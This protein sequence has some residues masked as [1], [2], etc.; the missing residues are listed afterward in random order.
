[1]SISSGIGDDVGRS[2]IPSV[3]EI[4]TRG[5]VNVNRE[6]LGILADTLQVSFTELG[7]QVWKYKG[8][9]N[10]P[11]L[12]SLISTRMQAPDF[13]VD[14]QMWKQYYEDLLKNLPPSIREKLEYDLKSP[15]KDRDN[16]YLALED[17]LTATARTLASIDASKNPLEPGSIAQRYADL[18]ALLPLFTAT[19]TVQLGTEFFEKAREVL[20]EMGANYVYRDKISDTINQAQYSLDN[21]QQELDAH[22]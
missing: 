16:A 14:N 17:L 12:P 5:I 15:L 8:S 22:D 3:F 4:E 6:R 18:N 13:S 1:M 7:G 21:M 9:A 10:R 20:N 2:P 11:V 19:S